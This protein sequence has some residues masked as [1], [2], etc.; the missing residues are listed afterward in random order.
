MK[1]MMKFQKINNI[2]GKCFSNALMF[3]D[4]MDVNRKSCNVQSGILHYYDK[5]KQVD[6]LVCHCW[7][8]SDGVDVETSYE[9]Q[10]IPYKISYYPVL[11]EFFKSHDIPLEKKKYIIE[12][13]TQFDLNFKKAI[14]DTRMVPEYYKK[15]GS[16]LKNEL[17]NK[18]QKKECFSLV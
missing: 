9:Y 15:L 12:Q 13:V 7:C 3:Y 16:Y 6:V 18:T 4:Y 8:K 2:K 14:R 1:A 17:F 10:S 11:G 5:K